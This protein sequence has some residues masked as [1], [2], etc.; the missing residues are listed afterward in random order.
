VGG[1][2]LEGSNGLRAALRPAKCAGHPELARL[3]LGLDE[4]EL[5]VVAV[6]ERDPCAVMLGVTPVSLIEDPLDHEG[7]VLRD[8]GDQPL[9]AGG[10][11]ACETR[12]RRRRRCRPRPRA[13]DCASRPSRAG[14]PAW[15][16][17]GRS[18]ARMTTPLPSRERTSRSLPA[19][20][21]GRR[22]S[23]QKPSKSAAA[24]GTSASNWR[25]PSFCPVARSMAVR[26][27]SNEPRV[28]SM[29]VS[30]RSPCEWSS[31]GRFSTA[32]AG[33]RLAQ[34]RRR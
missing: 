15:G 13:C 22:C 25:L 3:G 20:A 31:S 1:R 18:R 19:P 30:R 10:R 29:A 27:S 16:G 26:A 2:R 5:M 34:P 14:S 12:G 11:R 9:V 32:S 24:R 8:A 23:E 28:L 6:D 33:Y 17:L 4:I 21:A 7:G